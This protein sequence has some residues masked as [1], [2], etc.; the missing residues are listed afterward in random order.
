MTTTK[1]KAKAN[2]TQSNE[3]WTVRT[4]TLLNKNRTFH[5]VANRQ[6]APMKG[7]WNN[8]KLLFVVC[9]FTLV[10]DLQYFNGDGILRGKK[11]ENTT[12]SSQI[13]SCVNVNRHLSPFNT[14]LMWITLICHTFITMNERAH[15]ISINH[16]K[17]TNA[18][19]NL[20]AHFFCSWMWIYYGE[21]CLSALNGTML[22][23]LPFAILTHCFHY[24]CFRNSMQ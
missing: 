24:S 21:R 23:A 20:K 6:L 22:C 16:S 9:L 18:F 15:A 12:S 14:H 5:S 7:V 13:W 1:T 2:K 4:H 11:K 3:T 10:H 17:Q 19:C 8:S